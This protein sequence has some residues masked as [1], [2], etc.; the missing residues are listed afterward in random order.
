MSNIVVG[1]CTLHNL[2]LMFPDGLLVPRE[3]DVTPVVPAED[4]EAYLAN[5]TA[6][7]KRQAIC[8]TLAGNLQQ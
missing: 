3:P 7:A 5:A 2:A 8:Y 1:C 4:D 6:A